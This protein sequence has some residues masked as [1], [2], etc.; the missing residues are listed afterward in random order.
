MARMIDSRSV[1][2]VRD[3]DVSTRYY[4]DVLGFKR[5][6]GDG[7]DGW[8][9]LSRDGFK[10]MLGHCADETPAGE[11]GNHSYFA[12]VLVDGV[13]ELHKEISGRDADIMSALASKPWGLREF[14]VRTPD[15]HR[16]MFGEPLPSPQRSSRT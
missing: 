5:D 8:S 13:D 7:T 12:Y 2:A 16:I 4:M 11:L 6:F 3:L 9:F 10:V 1:L 15:G 14:G